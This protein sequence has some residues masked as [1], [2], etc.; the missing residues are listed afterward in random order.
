VLPA[1]HRLRSSDGFRR[2]MRGRRA[3][4]GCVVCHLLIPPPDSLGSAP[5]ADEAGP[6]P[7]LVGFVVSKAVGGSVV[8]SR[9][10]RRLRHV[11]RG[12]VGRLPVG[13]TLVVRA[14]PEAATATSERLAA[15]VAAALDRLL[16][17]PTSTGRRRS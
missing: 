14:R 12:E 16:L 6:A 4:R 9:V 3:A 10:S 17:A 2:A 8:R 5:Q 13:S 11:L 1:E 7:A 15:D